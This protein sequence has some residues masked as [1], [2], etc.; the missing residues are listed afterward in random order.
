MKEGVV[1]SKRAQFNF[2]WI[3]A[4]VI[5]GAILFLAVMEH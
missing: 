3:F 5:G 1:I 4:L 2:V